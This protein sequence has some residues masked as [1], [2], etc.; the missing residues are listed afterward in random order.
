MPF[1]PIH[2]I[3]AAP[4]KAAAPR[5]FSVIIFGGTQIAMDIEPLIRSY[6][7]HAELH[8]V[9]HTP[10][11]AFLIAAACAFVWRF[12]ERWRGWTPQSRLMLWLSAFYGTFSHLY[13]DFL[14]HLDPAMYWG[15]CATEKM[16]AACTISVESQTVAMLALGITPVLWLTR[17]TCRQAARSWRYWK[18]RRTATPVSE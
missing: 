4:L 12:L 8:A 3:L 14:Y 1:T 15:R 5:H 18:D 9:S 6:L 11:A 13:F 10:L 2:M 17:V 16:D 7:G